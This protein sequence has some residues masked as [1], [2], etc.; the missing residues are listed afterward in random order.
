MQTNND[1][2]MAGMPQLQL[3]YVSNFPKIAVVVWT[4]SIV[5]CF[6]GSICLFAQKRV[7][8]WAFAVG[9]LSMIACF[10]FV[11]IFHEP[12]PFDIFGRLMWVTLLVYTAIAA[13]LVW[14]ALRL[15]EDGTLK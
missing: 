8:I 12:S 2:L 11:S 4:V 10:V 9:F 7:A 6:L 14:Y 3:E 15:S 1:A 13:F 5:A